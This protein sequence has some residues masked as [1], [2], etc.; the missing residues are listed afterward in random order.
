MAW[1]TLQILTQLDRPSKNYDILITAA[2]ES[3]DA[4]TRSMLQHDP[5][6]Q[7]IPWHDALALDSSCVIGISMANFAAYHCS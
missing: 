2:S 1:V 5:K 7:P 4:L 3:D 6:I